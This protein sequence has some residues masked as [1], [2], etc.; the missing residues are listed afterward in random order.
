MAAA[1]FIE[2]C[3]EGAALDEALKSIYMMCKKLDHL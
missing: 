2:E 3:A 1:G